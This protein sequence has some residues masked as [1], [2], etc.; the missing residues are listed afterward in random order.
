MPYLD[1]PPHSSDHEDAIS[2][3]KGMKHF[4][5]GIEGG[6]KANVEYLQGFFLLLRND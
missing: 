3:Y 1:L 5:D 6:L 2:F 4:G